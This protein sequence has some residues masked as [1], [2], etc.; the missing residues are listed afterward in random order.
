MQLRVIKTTGKAESLKVNEAIFGAPV[1]QTLL[2]QAVRV[3]MANERQGTAKVKNRGE[4]NATKKKVYK[5]KGTGGARHGA[6]SAPIFVGGGVT[7]GPRGNQNWSLNLSPVMKRKALISALSWQNE[8]ICVADELEASTGKT[9]ALAALVTLAAADKKAILVV[10]PKQMIKVERALQNIT[11]VAVV[12]AARLNAMDIVRADAVMMTSAAIEVIETRLAGSVARPK[13]YIAK[14]VAKKPSKK[15]KRAARKTAMK[16][17]K[18]AK[19]AAVV[20]KTI[21]T[22]GTKKVTKK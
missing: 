3:Y 6:K 7:F 18:T 19:T 1:N 13:V 16:S 17:K 4:V 15:E 11:G 9:K 8:Q 14:E 20:E 21:K 22:A 12:T 10:L 2:S 5:Q